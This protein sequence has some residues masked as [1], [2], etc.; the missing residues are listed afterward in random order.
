MKSMFRTAGLFVLA[1]TIGACGGGDSTGP[2]GG[3]G[4]VRA[5]V[6]GSSF[7][8]NLATAAV[9]KD[10][11]LSFAGVQ[12]QGGTTR[13][14]NIGLVNVNGPGT[15][16]FGGG[17]MHVVTYSEVQGTDAQNSKAWTANMVAGTGTVTVTELSASR[18][19]G[20]FSFTL[21]PG[22][23]ATGTKTLSNGTFDIRIQP[24]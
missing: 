20:T 6:D 2:G 14:I 8:A 22:F 18:A 10:G 21:Q 5:T 23:N 12:S 13:S 11:V 1:A 19:K 7:N 15:F 16:T 24:N 3:N 17:N 9:H 4:S